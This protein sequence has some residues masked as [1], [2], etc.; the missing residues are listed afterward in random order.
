MNQR[1]LKML[2]ALPLLA[3]CSA[4]T[5]PAGSEVSKPA[6]VETPAAIDPGLLAAHH[7]RLHQAT[8]RNGAHIDAL[9]VQADK[10]LQLDFSEGR[11]SI[12][13]ACNA[14]NGSV[15]IENG[16]LALGPMISTKRA[17][18][19][20]ALNNLDQAVAGRMQGSLRM[21]I[22]SGDSPMLRLHTEAGDSLE[23]SSVPTDATRFGSEG[24]TVFL[25]VAAQLQPCEQV[26]DPAARC[27]RVRE[28]HYDANGLQAAPPGEW[29]LLHQGIEGYSHETNVRNVLRLKRHVNLKEAADPPAV[30]LVL[31]MV[32][33]SEVV[34]QGGV[35]P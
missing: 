26:M 35:V 23:F 31:D 25:E 5:T 32:V 28:R 19:D 15:R 7:W 1:V 4:T 9:F 24:E 33:E 20:P 14:M 6:P 11:V 3:A 2:F 17:C 8:D 13:N 22:V 21:E 27:L 18:A 34:P 10:P 12:L 30:V 29:Y 16:R